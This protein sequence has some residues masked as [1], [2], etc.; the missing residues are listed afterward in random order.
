MRT[1]LVFPPF[2]LPSLYNLPPLG[3]LN[4]AAVL[5]RSGHDC[6]VIDLVLA[7]RL[8]KLPMGA[9]IY[10][11]S[12]RMILREEPD[13]AAFSVQCA[14]LPAVLRIAERLRKKKPDLRIVLGG[15]DA[16][17][18]A[19]RVLERFPWIDAVVRGEGEITFRELVSAYA[20]TGVAEGIAGVTWRRGPHRVR[21]PHRDLISDLDEL[22]S[23]DYSLVPHL[24]VYRDACGIPRSVAIVEAGR[25]C[26]HR[27]VYCSESRLWRRRS[28]TFSI[29]RTVREMRRLRDDFGAECFLLA[30]DQFTSDRAY[31]ES[32]CC[33]VMEEGLNS[34]P[35]YCISRLD[36]VD[37]PLLRL[38]RD[39]GCESMCYGI[40]SGSER[41]LAF[42]GKR[43]DPGILYQ[44]VRETTEEGMT[45]TLSFVI[46]FPDEERED[47]DA[48]LTLALQAGIQGNSNLL[49]QLP[50]VLPGTE[51]HRRYGDRLVRTADTY[52]SLGLEFDNGRRLEEDNRLIESDPLI[53]SAFHNLPCAGLPLQELERIAFWFP[54][55]AAVYPKS[56]LLLSLAIEKSVSALFALFMEYV[57]DGEGRPEPSLSS[58]DC[59]RHFPVFSESLLTEKKGQSWQHLPDVVLYESSALEAGI[60]Q[61]KKTTGT[62]DTSRMEER[63]PIRNHSAVVRNFRHN[64]PAVINDLKGGIFRERY[65]EE[66]TILVFAP[67]GQGVE[68]TEINE[69]GR[70]LL[71]L[72]DGSW[73]MDEI[74]R[75]LFLRFGTG[76]DVARF[77][78]ECDEARAALVAGGLL[79]KTGAT[80]LE[81]R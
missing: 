60:A 55:I 38:M 69:F 64:L 28:R 56:F 80:P 7:V 27:C 68:V 45:P 63:F 75:I 30:Y 61:S 22:P 62:A 17:F 23:P 24:S 33:A 54:L 49:I 37:R 53:F 77:R 72:S 42:I 10:E 71:E 57:A 25:G 78:E 51:L 19:E 5:R 44:R 13:L 35:W 36:S 8:G 11:E 20:S 47:I 6:A 43:I 29:P 31:V 46:G 70:D 48:T 58:A 39:A 34:T 66:P 1:A 81:R 3:L 40:D 50:T 32:F 73:N 67:S 76:M 52:F 15:H 9:S 2:Y 74:A 18:V 65:K 14:T 12:A 59:L 26:P 4:L 16:S 21:N 79:Q 41:T